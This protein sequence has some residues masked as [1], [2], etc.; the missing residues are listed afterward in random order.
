[1]RYKKLKRSSRKLLQTAIIVRG[2]AARETEKIT[3][4]KPCETIKTKSKKTG[5]EGN[6][7]VSNRV[8]S[9]HET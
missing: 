2:L 5:I 6:D 4:V 3:N 8:V 1:M 7:S 9:P